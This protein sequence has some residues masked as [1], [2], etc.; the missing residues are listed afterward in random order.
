MRSGI[1]ED[2]TET[3]I[4]LFRCLKKKKNLC[5]ILRFSKYH[6]EGTV[7]QLVVLLSGSL[8]VCGVTL[9]TVSVRIL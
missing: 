3:A 6:A 2:G 4:E 9:V 8:R 7:I 5:V 1:V